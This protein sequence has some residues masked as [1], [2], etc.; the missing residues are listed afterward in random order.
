MSDPV[1]VVDSPAILINE[2]FGGVA[3][4][5]KCSLH[6]RQGNRASEEAHNAPSSPST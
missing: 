5:D 4:G 1:A 6:V 2:F 3:S